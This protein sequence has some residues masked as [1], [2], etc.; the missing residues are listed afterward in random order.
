M[1]RGMGQ[2]ISRAVHCI[3]SAVSVI[4]AVR[5]A[6]LSGSCRFDYSGPAVSV[7]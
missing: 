4:P 6:R 2:K 3:A 1:G 7:L 5:P